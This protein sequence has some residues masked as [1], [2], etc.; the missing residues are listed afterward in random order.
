MNLTDQ[1]RW[2]DIIKRTGNDHLGQT[3]VHLASLAEAVH[4]FDEIQNLTTRKDQQL[5][6]GPDPGFVVCGHRCGATR[7]HRESSR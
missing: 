4:R 1:T 2:V 7:V 3:L 5:V 6:Y